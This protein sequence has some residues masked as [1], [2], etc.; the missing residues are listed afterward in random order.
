MASL[1]LPP[2]AQTV[3]ANFAQ[4]GVAVVGASH[5]SVGAAAQRSFC[6]WQPA[7]AAT[8]NPQPQP[9]P[10]RIAKPRCRERRLFSH[11]AR[12]A[13]NL[14]LPAHLIANAQLP[15]SP[16]AIGRTFSNP[17]LPPPSHPRAAT[18]RPKTASKQLVQSVPQRSWVRHP[19]AVSSTLYSDLRRPDDGAHVSA[20]AGTN[21]SDCAMAM[22]ATM[23]TACHRR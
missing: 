22:E 4:Y 20:S 8:W 12:V 5:A 17:S 18:R 10:S 7:T 14:H 6:H 11:W 15:S 19:E 3:R 9:R 2:S 23:T 1:P 16:F 13:T 21:A